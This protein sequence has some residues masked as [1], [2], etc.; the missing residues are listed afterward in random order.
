M[1]TLDIMDEQARIYCHQRRYSEAEDLQLKQMVVAKRV[2][3]KDHSHTLDIM[4]SLVETHIQ[5]KRL[6]GAGELIGQVLEANKKKKN[7]G[8]YRLTLDNMHAIAIAY[9]FQERWREAEQLIMKAIE[10][11]T[12]AV[13]R[14]D[15]ETLSSI[16]SLA[17]TYSGQA[18]WIDTEEI[19]V[20]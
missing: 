5:Q 17:D 19:L 18:R 11:Q 20:Q 1:D 14:E 10:T 13:E 16:H 15:S 6:A 9:N 3:G 8:D 4:T 2:L 12:D 7:G